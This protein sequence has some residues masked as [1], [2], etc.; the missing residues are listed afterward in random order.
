MSN[1][2]RSKEIGVFALAILITGTINSIRNLPAMALFGSSLLF[3]FVLSMVVFLIPTASV[4]MELSKKWPEHGGIYGWTR[5]AFGERAGFFA[6]WLQWVNTLVWYPTMMSFI[7]G[8]AAYLIDPNLAQNKTY[9]VCA[10]L[11]VFW[12]STL[13]NL[14]GFQKSVKF[15]EY[16]GVIGMVI[17]M[18]MIVVLALIWIILGKPTQIHFTQSSIIPNFGSTQSWIALTAIATSLLGFE[19]TTVHLKHIKSPHT[20][21]TAMRVAVVL[22]VGTL[23]FGSLGIAFVLPVGKIN[24]VD[25]TLQAFVN[26]LHA[27]HLGWVVPIMVV[28]IVV[29]SI[30]GITNW[31]ISPAQGLLQAGK[32]E[33]IPK[34]LVKENKHGVPSRLMILQSVLVSIICMV[35]LLIPS[36]NASYWFLT[37]LS[38]QL[39]VFMYFIMFLTAIRLR[40][41]SG[42]G[43]KI[44][45]FLGLLGCLMII[46]VGFFPP[47]TLEIGSVW[48][49]ETFFVGGLIVL[50]LPS[51]LMILRNHL[52][53]LRGSRSS[54]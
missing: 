51:L 38:T 16:C 29:G 14:R 13:I 11:C 1:H 24:L 41:K 7:V 53:T 43:I 49:Y 17:P 5:L 19:L 31:I 18:A 26:F 39:Y 40:R 4:S 45:H 10:I 42:G 9:L 30:G 27:F 36:I 23:L 2:N 44:V 8:T 22:I 20:L 3:F 32:S 50:I 54:I 46:T 12:L 15:A 35:F 21:T 6:V 47:T 33:H 52:L 25:G 34:F 37:D 28:M 48:K